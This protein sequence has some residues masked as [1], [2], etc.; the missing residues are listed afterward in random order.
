[1]V[2]DSLWPPMGVVQKMDHSV[3]DRE[4]NELFSTRPANS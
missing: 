3:K 4:S 1:M 2:I